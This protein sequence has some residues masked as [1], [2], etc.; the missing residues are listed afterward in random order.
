MNVST[1]VNADLQK[2]KSL[3]AQDMQEVIPH[4]DTS[5]AVNSQQRLQRPHLLV[6]E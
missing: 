6:K 3:V 4:L 5:E 2:L 1:A